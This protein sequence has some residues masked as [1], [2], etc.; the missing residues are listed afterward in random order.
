MR[1]IAGTAKSKR[2]VAPDVDTTR[3]VTDRVRE[4]VFNMLGPWVEDGVVADLY[5][6]SGSFGL[7]AL[8]RGAATAL[9]VES[10]RAA[11]GALTKNIDRVGLGGTVIAQDVAVFVRTNEEKFHLVFIDP[12]WDLATPILTDQLALVDTMLLPDAEVVLSRRHTDD[13]P[14]P[15]P[16]WKTLTDRSYGDTRVFRYE[17]ENA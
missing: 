7:E 9:F 3:P 4:A 10:G 11:I 14:S 8:S 17:K 16:G 1:I 2:L 5:A 12:P 15:P 13:P 6:G